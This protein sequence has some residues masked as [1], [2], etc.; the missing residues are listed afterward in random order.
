MLYD[1]EANII[2]I[3]LAG[4]VISHARVFGNFIIHFS[5]TEKP[6]MVE[7]L[8]ADKFHKQFNKTKTKRILGE[9]MPA[10]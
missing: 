2:S 1:P 8:D 5:K 9:A 4:G 3:E 7:M 10:N 6:I